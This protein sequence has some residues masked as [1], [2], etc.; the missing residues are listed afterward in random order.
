MWLFKRTLYV[1]SHSVVHLRR[2]LN[3]II[4]RLRFRPRTDWTVQFPSGVQVLSYNPSGAEN[5]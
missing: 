4:Y 3:V 5:C 1:V 2:F